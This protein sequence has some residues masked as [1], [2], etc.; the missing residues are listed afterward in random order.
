MAMEEA[1]EIAKK[2]EELG[3]REAHITLGDKPERRYKAARDS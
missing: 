2:G 3:C 1:L